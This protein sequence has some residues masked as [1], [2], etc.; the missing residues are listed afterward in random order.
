MFLASQRISKNFVGALILALCWSCSAVAERLHPNLTVTQSDIEAIK[1]GISAVP[2]A[3][4]ALVDL[5]LK[6]DADL[7]KTMDVPVPKDAGGGYTHEQ[8]KLNYQSMYN[9]GLLFQ[10][11]GEDK[12][13]QYVR[14]MLLQYVQLYPTLG[15]HP[16]RKEQTPGKLFWQSLNE[17]VWL[18]AHNSSLRFRCQ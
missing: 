3:Q 16:K 4:K 15:I 6:V 8:H 18:G 14:E 11:T 12:Y 2:L 5:R 9:A 10:L 1:S 13:L 17:S 7:S